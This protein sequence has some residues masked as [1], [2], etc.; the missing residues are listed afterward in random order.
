MRGLKVVG[1]VALLVMASAWSAGA[2]SVVGRWGV[3]A[4]AN[5]NVPT[6]GFRDW[7]NNANKFGM[8]LSYVPATNVTVEVE[9][10][11]TNFDKGSLETRTFTWTDGKDYVSPN[12]SSDM[13]FNSFLV[14]GLVRVGQHGEAFKAS[15]FTPYIAVGGGFYRYKNQVSGLLWPGQKNALTQELE[16]F[17]DQRYALGFNAGLGVEAFV[18]DN[19][20][21]DLRGRYNFVIGQLR[22]LEDWG[23]SETFPLQLLDIGAG[24]KFYFGGE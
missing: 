6:F 15:G 9:L 5:Y 4:F 17:T 16:S 20:A 18:I 13:S 11:R 1:L 19:V 12:A 24:I 2:Q 23:L 22:P 21:V 10:H 7:Y 3:G 14:N 8:T